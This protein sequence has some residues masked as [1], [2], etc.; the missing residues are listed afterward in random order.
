MNVLKRI[1]ARAGLLF[2]VGLGGVCAFTWRK[3]NSDSAFAHELR[4]KTAETPML[5]RTPRV[6]ILVAA[7]N[8]SELLEAHIQ[9]VLALRYPNKE[10]IL[11][12]GGKDDT[13]AIAQ[14]YA[15]E[16]VTVIEQPPGSG[17]QRALQLCLPHATGEIIFLTD[18]D[19]TLNDDIFERCIAPLVNDGEVAATGPTRPVTWQLTMP[20]VLHRWFNELYVESHSGDYSS[21]LLGMNAALRRDLLTEIGEF[22]DEV[23]TG[24]DYHMAKKLLQRGYRIRYVKDSVVESRFITSVER[25]RRQQARWLRNVVMYGLRFG[26]YDEVYRCLLPTFIATGML[27]APLLAL[28]LG[29]IVLAGW[30]VGWVFV[31]LNRARYMRFGEIRTGQSFGTGYLLLPFYTLLDFTIWAGL[32]VQYPFKRFRT[33]W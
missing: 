19:C 2:V 13:C 33:K 15:G 23:R 16:N 10:L 27:T 28:L 14:R 21:G 25:Y 5:N 26:A 7:W 9:S 22:R 6:S 18:A 8:E 3:W 30:A 29:P 32:L 4:A 12:A 24:T 31:I 20:F 11:C 17:K 1:N